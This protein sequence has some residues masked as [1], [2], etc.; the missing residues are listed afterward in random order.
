MVLACCI[1]IATYCPASRLSACPGGVIGA[2]AGVTLL[3]LG[4]ME[5]GLEGLQKD[6]EIFPPEEV[7]AHSVVEKVK[8]HSIVEKRPM[9]GFAASFA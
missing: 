1:L 8:A 2:G 3:Y 6:P 7:K 5:E 9:R 4:A